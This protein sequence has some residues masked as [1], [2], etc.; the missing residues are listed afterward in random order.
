VA[1][2]GRTSVVVRDICDLGVDGFT[3]RLAVRALDADLFCRL[4]SLDV[5]R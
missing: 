1:R 5:L 2:R 3:S 4:V